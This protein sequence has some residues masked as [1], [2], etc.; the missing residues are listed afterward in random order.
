L[1]LEMAINITT[2]L[3]LRHRLLPT[4][5][6][7]IPICNIRRRRSPRKKPNIDIRAS[8]LS[9]NDTATDIVE[10]SAVGL[11]I[12]ILDIAACVGALAYGVY[13]A[14]CGAESTGEAAVVGDGAAVGCVEGHGIVGV[15][16]DAFNYVDFAFIGPVWADEP[17]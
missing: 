6:I 8:P 14:V 11:G 15:V 2:T 12:L 7:W 17:V 9:R 1:I 13:V 4:T 10:A 5:R 3:I 16:V